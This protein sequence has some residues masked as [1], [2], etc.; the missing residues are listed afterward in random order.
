MLMELTQRDFTKI[1]FLKSSVPLTKLWEE[2]YR[3]NVNRLNEMIDH[4]ETM[5][6][7]KT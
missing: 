6:S 1:P 7:T 2:Y 3:I 4:V 5:K